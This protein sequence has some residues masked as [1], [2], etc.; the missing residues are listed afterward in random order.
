VWTVDIDASGS[1]AGPVAPER[2][3][4]SVVGPDGQ[5]VTVTQN[6]NEVSQV[7]LTAPFKTSVTARKLQQGTYT[8]RTVSSRNNN[9]APDSTCEAT[10]TV[11]Q[12]HANAPFVDG[13]FGKE[14]R[15]RGVDANGDPDGTPIVGAGGFCAPLLGISAGYNFLLENDWSIAPRGGLAI[16]FDDG[17]SSSLFAEVEVDKWL[18]DNKS[19]VGTGIG[20]WDF[21]HSDSD[22]AS[23]L[24]HFG[25]LI[26]ENPNGSKLF[27]IGEGRL[28][29]SELD[30]IDN[31][32]QFWG[33]VRYYFK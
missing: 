21:N 33:G 19:F 29:L 7:T 26:K 23:W 5:P 31:N 22:E 4:I 27:F 28:F 25:R 18:A 17:G 24:I 11:E 13:A 14:R 6:G 1:A 9:V 32:Y 8:L 16:N 3:T 15:V 20:W 10:F 2:V 30:D 12:F